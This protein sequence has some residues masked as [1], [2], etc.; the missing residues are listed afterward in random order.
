MRIALAVVP[1]RCVIE[2]INAD[3]RRHVGRQTAT[4]NIQQAALRITQAAA[5]CPVPTTCLSRT[6]AAH[7]VMSRLGLSSVPRIGVSTIDG[8]F[9]AHAWLECQDGL[10]IGHESPD[11]KIY[12]PVPSIERFFA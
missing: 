4:L 10:V 1:L 5:F 7:L 11:G 6:L 8:K 12:T 9:E 3:Q 2:W